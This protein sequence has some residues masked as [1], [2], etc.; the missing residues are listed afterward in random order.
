[1]ESVPVAVLS[2]PLEFAWKY[3]MPWLL[4]LFTADPTLLAVD[5]VPFALYVVYDGADTLPVVGSYV[6]PPPSAAAV[7]PPRLSVFVETVPRPVDS[8][9][10]LVEVDV[11]SDVMELFVELSPVDREPIPD[12]VEV[13]NDNTELLVELRPVDSELILVDVEVDRLV[14]LDDVVLATE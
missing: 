1:M 5:V 13:D 6:E 4:M 9:P 10:M 8:E 3:L 12:D 11:E 14:M 2:A 7:L